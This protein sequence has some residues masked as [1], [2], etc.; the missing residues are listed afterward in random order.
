MTVVAVTVGRAKISPFCLV[1]LQEITHPANT[2]VP[3]GA[4]PE[5]AGTQLLLNKDTVPA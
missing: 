3:I 2:R 4:D 5:W 1:N